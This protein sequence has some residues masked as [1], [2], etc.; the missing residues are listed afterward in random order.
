[1]KTRNNN[2]WRKRIKKVGREWR[3]KEWGD[4]EENDEA[5][6]GVRKLADQDS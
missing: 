6:N 5:K 2:W 1:M 3:E 4:V